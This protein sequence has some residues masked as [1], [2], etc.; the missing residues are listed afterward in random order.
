MSEYTDHYRFEAK[1]IYDIR[2]AGLT[3]P[4]DISREECSFFKSFI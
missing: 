4:D 2:D 3:T 1:E